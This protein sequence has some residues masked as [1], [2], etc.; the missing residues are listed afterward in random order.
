M[1]SWCL[2]VSI[3]GKDWSEIHRVN[4]N[5]DQN[6]SNRITAYAATKSTICR[7]IRLGQTGKNHY[8]SNHLDVFGLEIF[9]SLMGA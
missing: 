7:M 5:N 1:K 8:G 3:D 6:G 2:E 4:D 9:G